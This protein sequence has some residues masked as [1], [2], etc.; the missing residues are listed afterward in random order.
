VTTRKIEPSER[1]AL[2][3]V[4][5]AAADILERYQ[6]MRRCSSSASWDEHENN[7]NN[8]DNNNETTSLATTSLHML[9]ELIASGISLLTIG[10][11]Y[12]ALPVVA[13]VLALPMQWVAEQTVFLQ[14]LR[15]FIASNQTYSAN[16]WPPPA[17]LMLALLTVVALII[18][19]PVEG[20][21]WGML[22]SLRYVSVSA[23]K[24]YSTVYPSHLLY[25]HISHR[26]LFSY[27][28][29]NSLSTEAIS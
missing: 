25:L 4:D 10:W 6:E 2:P 23:G 27:T 5:R 20:L 11:I 19:H 15:F 9:Y 22:R 26:I 12:H 16:S 28:I 7:E 29:H 14:H 21:T 8:D 13:T 3:Q 18:V 1:N 17:L 24:K